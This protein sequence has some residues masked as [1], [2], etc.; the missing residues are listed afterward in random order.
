MHLYYGML[1]QLHHFIFRNSKAAAKGTGNWFLWIMLTLLN[2]SLKLIKF[3]C[4][5]KDLKVH[6]QD[7]Q[8]DNDITAKFFIVAPG[9][10]SQE[11]IITI[12]SANLISH[13]AS[14]FFSILGTGFNS[15]MD[16]DRLEYS[17]V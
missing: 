15:A 1:L 4:I 14:R 17:V 10:R 12:V 5:G 13:L 16:I 8:L 2:S 9:T 11:L 6:C 3:L 7:I